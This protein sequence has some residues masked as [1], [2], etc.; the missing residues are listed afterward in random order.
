MSCTASLNLSLIRFTY[1]VIVIVLVSASALI[2]CLCM[3]TTNFIMSI[4]LDQYSFASSTIL[5]FNHFEH[6]IT[7][8]LLML[9]D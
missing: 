7:L 9:T 3:C 8:N 2:V 1:T 6:G 4:E 5:K